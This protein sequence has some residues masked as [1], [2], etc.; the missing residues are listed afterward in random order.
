MGIQL[1]LKVVNTIIRTELALIY[2]YKIAGPRNM[3]RFSHCRNKISRDRDEKIERFP[4][5]TATS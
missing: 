2:G 1:H 4:T 5:Q 3:K